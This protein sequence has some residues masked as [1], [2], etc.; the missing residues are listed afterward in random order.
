MKITELLDEQINSKIFHK[1]FLK[2]K[3]ILDSRYQLIARAGWPGPQDTSREFKITAVSADGR[4]V[5]W[6]T[7]IATDDH[8]LVADELQVQPAH[9]RR[10]IASEIYKFVSE[11]GN[12]IVPSPLQTTDGKKFWA[13][14]NK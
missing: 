3:S 9:R 10:G 4:E 8:N 7:F 12:S 5:A 6:A 11:L 2:K 14:R 1:N 13:S